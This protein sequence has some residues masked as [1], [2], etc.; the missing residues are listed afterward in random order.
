MLS[1]QKSRYHNCGG[2]TFSHRLASNAPLAVGVNA[3]SYY[4]ERRSETEPECGFLICNISALSHKIFTIHLRPGGEIGFRLE[5]RG[6]QTGTRSEDGKAADARSEGSC[7]YSDSHQQA[8]QGRDGFFR[9]VSS[10]VLRD[11]CRN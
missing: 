8:R 11:A 5:L 3:A 10:C 9:L 4:C 6:G 7:G 2:T 1:I